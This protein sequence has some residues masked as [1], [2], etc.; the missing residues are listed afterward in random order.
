MR[1]LRGFNILSSHSLLRLIVIA[2]SSWFK[3]YSKGNSYYIKFEQSCVYLQGKWYFKQWFQQQVIRNFSVSFT[4]LIKGSCRFSH[5]YLSIILY[6][7]KGIINREIYLRYLPIRS[8]TR[9]QYVSSL[10][11]KGLLLKPSRPRGQL[12][13]F[14]FRYRV[15][16]QFMLIKPMLV[17][18]LSIRIRTSF[19]F[20]S[21]RIS[22]STLRELC[23]VL[24]LEEPRYSY[25]STFY[26]KARLGPRTICF[27]S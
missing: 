23:R 1:I 15:F 16:V 3:V 10:Y 25:S 12:S 27:P 7:F 14:K 2:L 21:I 19:Y 26:P 17:A 20:L 4:Q 5:P 24:A 6:C 22:L 13:S 9:A 8:F 18:P 11:I